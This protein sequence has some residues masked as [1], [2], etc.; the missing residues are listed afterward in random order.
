[1]KGLSPEGSAKMWMRGAMTSSSVLSVT[2]PL[3]TAIAA[4]NVAKR[5]VLS[6]FFL[7]VCLCVCVSVSVCVCLSVSL[8]LFLSLF[9]IFFCF[10]FVL[11][12]L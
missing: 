11:I 10:C 3:N 5:Y 12:V 6:V 2:H 4:R 8:S 7:C 9:F 1:M